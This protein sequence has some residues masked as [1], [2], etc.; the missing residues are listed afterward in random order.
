MLPDDSEAHNV[1]P[2]HGQKYSFSFEM[3]GPEITQKDAFVDISQPVQNT[4][5]W[6]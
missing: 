5:G 3:F 1:E 6:V 2:Q 4:F